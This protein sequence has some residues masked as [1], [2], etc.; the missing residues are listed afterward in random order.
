MIHRYVAEVL[1]SIPEL[2]DSWEMSL[3]G[4]DRTLIDMVQAML[5]L[6][7]VPRF[8]IL[9]FSKSPL[10]LS[11]SLPL[12]SS[13]PLFLSSSLPHLPLSLSLSL[14][15]LPLSLP[16]CPKTTILFLL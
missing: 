1:S 5:I 12:S 14:T 8:F 13:L 11:L 15:P 6:T 3:G 7:S 9:I 10:S 4:S 16:L 2:G